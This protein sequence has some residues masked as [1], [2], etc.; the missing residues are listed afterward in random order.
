MKK[1]VAIL[2]AFACSGALACN[3]SDDEELACEAI[4]CIIGINE[5]D[6]RDQCVEIVN[7]WNAYLSNL[8]PWDDPQACYKRDQ[9]CNR[10][11][12][13]GASQVENE[14]GVTQQERP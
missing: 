1:V 7:E 12:R 8:H 9:D 4:M 2:G 11:E 6:S 14:S 3:M 5:D 13:I 10:T